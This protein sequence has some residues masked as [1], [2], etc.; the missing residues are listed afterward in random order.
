M[1]GFT[2]ALGVGCSH[3]HVEIPGA[4]RSVNY[5]SDANPK[6]QI[7]RVMMAMTAEINATVRGTTG[8]PAEEAAAVTC[9]T[10][11]RARC[12]AH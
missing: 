10:C 12:R 7:A 11:H 8:G 4:Q 3:C 5:E 2:R 1:Q 6:K 9:A